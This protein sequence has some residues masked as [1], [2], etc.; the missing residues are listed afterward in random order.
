MIEYKTGDLLEATE[1]LIAHQCNCVSQGAAGIAFYIFKKYPYSN[2]YAKRIFTH[3]ADIPGTIKIHGDGNLKRYVLNMYSQYLPG[4]PNMMD[5]D[6]ESKRENYFQSCLD[7]I[8]LIHNL[9]SVAFPY[10]IGCGIAGGN[11]NNYLKMLEDFSNKTNA[12]IVIYQ[13]L[14]DM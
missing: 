6:T 1:E 9:K 3:K 11:W 14:E 4:G 12:K 2:D 13:R 8:L 7:K 10:K 5:S